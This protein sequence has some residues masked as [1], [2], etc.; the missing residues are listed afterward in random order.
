M[1]LWIISFCTVLDV[2]QR[3]MRKWLHQTWPQAFTLSVF[4]S[5][6]VFVILFLSH[7]LNKGPVGAEGCLDLDGEEMGKGAA[8]I[9]MCE[10]LEISLLWS[11]KVFQL[12]RS[13]GI[14]SRGKEKYFE[15]GWEHLL[16]VVGGNACS[17]IKATF[18]LFHFRWSFLLLLLLRWTLASVL[19]FFFPLPDIIT[20]NKQWNKKKIDFFWI[21][22]HLLELWGSLN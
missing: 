6:S 9:M 16:Y 2:W 5:L 20:R 15:G 1:I 11:W 17:T 7:S 19:S 13:K 10:W 22:I 18:P 12:R 14:F 3:V 8:Q 4:L 21:I